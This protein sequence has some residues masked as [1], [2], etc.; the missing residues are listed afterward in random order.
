MVQDTT[1]SVRSDGI[2]KAVSDYYYNASLASGLWSGVVSGGYY[3][4]G[5]ATRVA[6]RNYKNDVD[7]DAADTLTVNAYVWGQGGAVLTH[8]DY[9]KDTGDSSNTVWT[10]AYARD[11]SGYLTGATITDE[12]PRTVTLVNDAQ[13]RVLQR[14]EADG[15]ATTGDPRQL[16]YYMNGVPV[17]DISNNGTSNTDYASSL[18][19]HTAPPAYGPFQGGVSS[20]MAHADFDQSYDAINGLTYDSTAQSYTVQTGDTLSAIAQQLW[21]DASL[22]YLI[23]EA[24]GLSGSEPLAPG[25]ILTLPNK[26]HNLHN[27]ATT[28]RPYDPNQAQG[29]LSPTDAK[30]PKSNKCGTFGIILMVVIAVAVTLVAT[31]GATALLSGT[32]FGGVLG[33]M[34]GGA[35][36]SGVGAGAWIAGAAIGGAIGS[37]ASQGFGIAIGI[38]H[39]INWKGVAISAISSAVTAGIG[40]IGSAK[41]AAEAL[42]IASTVGAKTSQLGNALSALASGA[43]RG[44]AASAAT[45]GIARVTHLQNDFDFLGIAMAGLGGGVGAAVGSRLPVHNNIGAIGQGLAS[46]MASGI[47]TATARSIITGSDFGDNLM[48]ALPDI[49]GQ[50]IGSMMADG[51]GSIGKPKATGKPINLLDEVKDGTFSSEPQAGDEPQT[52]TPG[53]VIKGGKLRLAGPDL[54]GFYT[55]NLTGPDSTKLTVFEWFDQNVVQPAKGWVDENIVEPV[56]SWFDW[57]DSEPEIVVTGQRRQAEAPKKGS[58][59][60]FDLI[61]GV[62]GTNLGGHNPHTQRVRAVPRPMPNF[63]PDYQ[64][65]RNA[66]AFRQPDVRT[67]PGYDRMGQP[68]TGTSNYDAYRQFGKIL[69]DSPNAGVVTTLSRLGEWLTYRVPDAAQRNATMSDP[70]RGMTPQGRAFAHRMD[71]LEGGTISGISTGIAMQSGASDRT[72]DLVHGLGSSADGFLIAGGSMA[73]ARLPGF[74]NQLEFNVVNG[75]NGV[76]GNSRLSGRTTYLYELYQKDGTFLKYGISVSPS[77]RYSSIFMQDKDIFRITSGTRSDMMTLER[78]MVISNPAGQLNREAWAVK[79]RGGN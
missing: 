1:V 60:I 25:R 8:V 71:Q 3:M 70:Y 6:T 11:G 79:A 52:F 29:D 51:I 31:A 72:I 76:H 48:A 61:D 53:Y 18:A 44:A 20:G 2:F 73:G 54:A 17:G 15:N 37:V 34:T 5:A 39:S 30:K 35:A 45:Q 75:Q 43:L 55:V 22:W 50:T 16:H 42:K 46:G 41:Q 59:S 27:N 13:G 78:Q 40:Q 65:A 21:G 62:I 12:R 33:A 49:I 38:Q 47:A 32:S 7:T 64:A 58:R 67:G 23:A 63:S 66:V 24:N 36:I 57:G 56:E 10:S 14:D 69:Y 19:A 77:T 4:G 28:W 68:L 26:V 9:D 74:G